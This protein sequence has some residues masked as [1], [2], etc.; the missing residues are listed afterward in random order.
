MDHQAALPIRQPYSKK[1]FL[2]LRDGKDSTEKRKAIW[3]GVKL[4]KWNNPDPLQDILIPWKLSSKF[5][6]S[7]LNKTNLDLDTM[8]TLETQNIIISSFLTLFGLKSI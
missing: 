3:K 4:I 8:E 6:F 2:E 7:F 5:L 1:K